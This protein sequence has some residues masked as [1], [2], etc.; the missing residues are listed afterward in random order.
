MFIFLPYL[1]KTMPGGGIIMVIFFVAALFAGFTSLI[2]LFEAPVATVQ[3]KLHLGRIPAVALI[4]VLGMA[5][6]LSIQGIVSGWMDIC[7]IFACPTAPC[8]RGSCSSGYTAGRAAW[9]R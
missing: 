8:W 5:V 7:S 3:E 2:N 6:S 4:G 1:F 9:S